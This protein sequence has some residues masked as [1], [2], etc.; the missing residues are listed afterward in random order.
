MLTT[1][2]HCKGQVHSHLITYLTE[3]IQFLCFSIILT[4]KCS[5]EWNKHDIFLLSVK[6]RAHNCSTNAPWSESVI[7]HTKRLFQIIPDNQRR[8]LQTSV[9]Y[10][11]V[12]CLL[13][14]RSNLL[15]VID[16]AIVII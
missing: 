12:V 3:L 16:M 13:A 7:V 5:A 15:S 9:P 10:L 2:S 4:E 14:V 6:G 8:Y 11:G 1:T